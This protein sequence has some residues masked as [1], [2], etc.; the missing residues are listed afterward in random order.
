MKYHRLLYSTDICMI[1]K[2]VMNCLKNEGE[3]TDFRY[4]CTDN[5]AVWAVMIKAT[6][7]SFCLSNHLG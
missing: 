7:L 4:T 1:K 2:K 5:S 6:Y 3:K